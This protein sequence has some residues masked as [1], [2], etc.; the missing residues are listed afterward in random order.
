MKNILVVDDT[1]PLRDSLTRLLD[2]YGYHAEGASDG[3]DALDRLACAN[4]DLVLLDLM[5][6]R[7]NGV[8]FLHH[9]REDPQY[10]AWRDVPVVVFS[11]LT[12]GPQ[13]DEA[14]NLGV[15]HTLSK[16]TFDVDDLIHMIESEVND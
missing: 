15:K 6:P 1:S 9:L 7:V 10:S 8:E 2:T 4:P 12:T 11:A 13:L 14:R 16:A 5:M 3:R